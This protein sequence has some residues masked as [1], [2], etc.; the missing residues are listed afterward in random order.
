MLRWLKRIL[1]TLLVLVGLV[2]A[3][4]YA[5]SHAILTAGHAASPRAIAVSDDTETLARGKRL[6]QVYGCYM[7]CHGRDM[8]GD[9]FFEDSLFGKGVAPNLTAAV[10]KYTPEQFEAIVRQGIRPDGSAVVA[11]PSASFSTMT[12]R[13]LGAI[14]S[15]IAAYPEQTASDLGKTTLYPLARLFLVLGEFQLAPAEIHDRPWAEERLDDALS[16]GAY[17]AQNACSECHGLD[18]GGQEGFTPPLVIAKAYDRER[19]KRLMA[20]GVGIDESRDLGLMAAVSERRF[21][22]LTNDEVD[23]LFAYLQSR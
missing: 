23:D 2:F 5:W 17:L 14:Y 15:F 19:F 9:V 16:H 1:L 10:R 13:D 21:S 12:D 20:T 7:G 18:L 4:T 22:H 6:A 8:E 11:M 3:V